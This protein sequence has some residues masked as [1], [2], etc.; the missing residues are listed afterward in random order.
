MRLIQ[1][2]LLN[3]LIPMM[4]PHTPTAAPN[5]GCF[6]ALNEATEVKMARVSGWALVVSDEIFM[7]VCCRIVFIHWSPAAFN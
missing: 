4:A 3:N 2:I 7:C 6:V 1:I 5:S